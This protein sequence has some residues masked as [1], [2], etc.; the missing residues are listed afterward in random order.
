MRVVFLNGLKFLCLLAC[1]LLLLHN[2][3][4]LVFNSLF[5][6]RQSGALR[7]NNGI[8]VA[9]SETAGDKYANYATDK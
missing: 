3:P 2:L 4:I 1:L 9:D 6:L 7:Y 5:Q 8:Q